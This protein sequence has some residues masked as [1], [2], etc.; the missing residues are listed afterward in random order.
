MAELFDAYRN[1]YRDVVQSSIDFSGL[2]HHFFMRAKAHVLR[3]LIL[4]RLGT[5][6]P[7]MLDVGCGIGSFHPLLRGMV[8]RL[9]GIDVS[10]ACI[11]QARADNRDVQYSEFD[12]IN[13]PFDDASFDL[14][15]AICVMHHV[16]PPEWAGFMRE[17]R[18]VVRPGGLV[19]VIEHNPY[20]PLTRLAVARCEFDREA[21]L[22]SAGATRKL[23]VE[24]GLHEVGACHFLLLPWQTK[25]ARRVEHALRTLPLGAQYAAFGTA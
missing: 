23:M 16:A 7:A 2:P 22:L 21:V 25:P 5:E 6:K 1:N 14:V 15:T 19:C 4:P 17:M 10:S 18:R 3:E 11:A 8:G 20:N 9:S 13:F 24:G 12:G